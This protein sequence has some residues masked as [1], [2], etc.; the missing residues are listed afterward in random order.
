MLDEAR[1][2]VAVTICRDVF[3]TEL[4]NLGQHEQNTI[5]GSFG[6]DV[7]SLDNGE[8][9]ESLVESRID[10]VMDYYKEMATNFEHMVKVCGL[11]VN[12]AKMPL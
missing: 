11:D 1:I 3:T 6:I 12:D 4:D 5:L 10:K 8:Y 7:S 2:S 9:C